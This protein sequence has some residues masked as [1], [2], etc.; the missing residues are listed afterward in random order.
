MWLFQQKKGGGGDASSRNQN[1]THLRWCSV[2]FN[3]LLRKIQGA[4]FLSPLR[5]DFNPTLLSIIYFFYLCVFLQA[6][7]LLQITFSW[8][9]Q[10][11]TMPVFAQLLWRSSQKRSCFSHKRQREVGLLC[12]DRAIGADIQ[13]P[14]PFVPLHVS[15]KDFSQHALFILQLFRWPVTT[16]SQRT[17]LCF[18]E[19]FSN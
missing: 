7:P 17:R 9:C 14:I 11:C 12:H 13:E 10:S 6:F 8:S 5:S 18:G 1:Q 16:L 15:S 4:S 2:E 19:L 3:K